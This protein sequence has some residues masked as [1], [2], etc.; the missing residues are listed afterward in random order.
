MYKV[1]NGMHCIKTCFYEFKAVFVFVFNV[2]VCV[3]FSFVLFFSFFV[4]CFS[5]FRKTRKKAKT[6]E[7]YKKEKQNEKTTLIAELML[8]V[9][10]GVSGS[11]ALSHIIFNI[12]S[13]KNIYT[14]T[15]THCVSFFFFILLLFYFL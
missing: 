7:K 1:H 5:F 10:N 14:S 6:K 13:V 12:W 8:V 3:F 4:C 2:C 11:R 9:C 15:K